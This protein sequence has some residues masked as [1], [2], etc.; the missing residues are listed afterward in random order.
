MKVSKLILSV[1]F[2][3]GAIA[4]ASAASAADFSA[5]AP[6][7][8]APPAFS[9]TGCYVGVHGG[10]GVL[11]DQGFAGGLVDRDAIGALAGGQVGCN[12]QIGMLVLGV[13]G[14]GFWSGMTVQR[15]FFFGPVVV[16]SASVKNKWDY[17]VAARAGI[18]IDR[19]LIYGKAGWVAG[20]FDWYSADTAGVA[21]TRGSSTLQG[22]LIG[23]GMEYALLDSWTAKFE[24]DYLGF[25]TKNVNFTDVCSGCV[26]PRTDIFKE[27]VSADKHIFKVGVN[28][29]FY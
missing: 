9:W 15:D 23:L 17:D 1:A 18:A 5:K 29:K 12:Y 19:A 6:Y 8:A 24:Y 3:I 10:G 14:E 11:R 27:P 2:V 16:E 7:A 4:G 26:P 22:L 25:G 20:R 28:Y 13:E 21:S